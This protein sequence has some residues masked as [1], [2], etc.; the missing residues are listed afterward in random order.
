MF[1]LGTAGFLTTLD[2]VDFVI[3]LIVSAGCGALI[4]LEREKRYKN[5]GI[6][7]HVIVAIASCLMMIVSKYGFFD[8]VSI[9]GIRLQAD[10]SRIAHGVVSAIGFLGAGVIFVRKE[11]IVGLTTAAGLWAIVG[12]GI[13]IG[14]GLYFIGIFTTLFILLIQQ[15]LH[16]YHTRS[17]NKYTAG[18]ACNIT[19]HNLTLKVLKEYLKDCGFEFRE[20]TFTKN[21]KGETTVSVNVLFPTDEDMESLLDKLQTDDVL[22]TVEVLP[23]F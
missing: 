15:V 11:T 16:K 8:V 14:A 3:R 23:L 13:S 17:H 19:R 7:T 21:E 9:E 5:A 12:V 22:D 6:R 18:I 10:A 1:S 4:G 20:L 2:Y